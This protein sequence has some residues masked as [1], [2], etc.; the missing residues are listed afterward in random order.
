MRLPPTWRAAFAGATPRQRQYAAA[1]LIALGL[2][3]LFWLV[4]ALPGDGGN[5]KRAL[6]R[7]CLLYTSPSPRD[8]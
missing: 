3:G 6:L 4:F 5:A 7:P 8:S 1:A 2:F